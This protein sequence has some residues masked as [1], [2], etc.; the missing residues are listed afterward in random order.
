M[1]RDGK[2]HGWSRTCQTTQSASYCDASIASTISCLKRTRA[3]HRAVSPRQELPSKSIPRV[4]FGLLLGH[5]YI[6][7]RRQLE[8]RGPNSQTIGALRKGFIAQEATYVWGPL[9]RDDEHPPM[10]V[11]IAR[12]NPFLNLDWYVPCTINSI[13]DA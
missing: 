6:A 11:Q 10:T 3:G 1:R 9:V 12:P 13:D 2:S 7:L 8:R 4:W 5:A